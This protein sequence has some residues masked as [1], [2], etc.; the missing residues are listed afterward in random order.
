VT[1]IGP[2]TRDRQTPIERRRNQ[3]GRGFAVQRGRY[4]TALDRSTEQVV[5]PLASCALVRPYDL[6]QGWGAFNLGME[7]CGAVA[8]SAGWCSSD[9]ACKAS[10]NLPHL[11]WRCPSPT[12]ATKRKCATEEMSVVYAGPF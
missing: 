8:I 4:L 5:D 2:P 9:F 6:F 7:V 10:R 1:L 3:V 12:F 11:V